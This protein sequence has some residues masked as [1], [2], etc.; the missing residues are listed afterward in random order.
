MQPIIRS[1]AQ[2]KRNYKE[3]S[4]LCKETHSPVFLT[5]NGSID[6][7]AMDIETYDT[8]QQSL[9]LREKLVDI[10]ERRLAGRP[11][12]KARDVLNELRTIHK[13]K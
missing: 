12:L 4:D 8:R 5:K 7:V 13:S 9:E 6:L 11:D 1:S 10:A 3:I 2:I